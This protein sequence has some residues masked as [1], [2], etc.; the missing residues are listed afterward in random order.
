M[1]VDSL[2]KVMDNCL[3]DWQFIHNVVPGHVGR[4][5][6]ALR[7]VVC[8]VVERSK[9]EQHMWFE[10]HPVG[11]SSFFLSAVY[12]SN[13]YVKRRRL[14]KSLVDGKRDGVPWFI[15]TDFNVERCVEQIVGGFVPQD[16]AMEE[17][18]ECLEE[19]DVTEA[20]S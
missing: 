1:K 9:M 14:W 7:G 4:I 5:I 6:V 3:P 15:A 20:A 2:N 16:C 12:A 13:D 17:F 10:V 19:I 18:H 11:K 8:K